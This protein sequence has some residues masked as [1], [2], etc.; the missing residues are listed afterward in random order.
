MSEENKT[1]MVTKAEFEAQQEE[2]KKLKK[3]FDERQTKVNEQAEKKLEQAELTKEQVLKALGI[4]KDPDIDPIV[5]INEK[6]QNTNKTI[7][8]LQAQLKQKDEQ[9]AVTSKKSNAINLA[10]TL[11]FN[12]PEDALRF[13]DINSD[14]LENK[15]KELTVSRPYLLKQKEINVGNAF[16]NAQTQEVQASY[17]EIQKQIQKTLRR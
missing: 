12:D 5:S 9:L 1:E 17:D 10:K 8:D 13:V 16:N 6:L 3:I 14:D 15:L 7:E 2:L 11:N 4:E